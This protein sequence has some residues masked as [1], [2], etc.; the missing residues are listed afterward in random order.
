MIEAGIVL[1]DASA[2]NDQG[3]IVGWGMR[4]GRQVGYVLTPVPEPH[5]V[6]LIAGGLAALALSSR[7]RRRAERAMQ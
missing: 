4:N 7:R 3:Q 6:F 1:R 2:I 5:T